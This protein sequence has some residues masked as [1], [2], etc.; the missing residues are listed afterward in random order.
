MQNLQVLTD[1]SGGH[2]YVNKYIS[3]VDKQNTVIVNAHPHKGNAVRLESQFL[4]N[5]KITTSAINEEKNHEKKRNSWHPTG[6]KVAVPEMLHLALGESEVHTNMSWVEIPTCPLELRAGVE[7][8]KGHRQNANNRRNQNNSNNNNN[9]NNN[10]NDNNRYRNNNNRTL[11]LADAASVDSEINRIRKL[12][13]LPS[14]R[15][16]RLPELYIVQ[17]TAQCSITID[18]VTKFSLRPPELRRLFDSLLNYY[19]WFDIGKEYLMS[20]EMMVK[21]QTDITKTCWIDGLHHQV[22]IRKKAFG[23]VLSYLESKNDQNDIDDFDNQLFNFIKEI[24]CLQQQDHLSEEQQIIS[25]E[26]QILRHFAREELIYED[27][28][29]VF[30]HVPVPS[31]IT[32]QNAHQF[33]LHYLLKYGRFET[34]VDLT[35][36]PS[37]RDSF[38]YAKLIGNETDENSLIRYSNI[39]LRKYIVE[40]VFEYSFSIKDL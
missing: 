36:H 6:A 14:E 31:L 3:K 37:V 21:V 7:T 40:E 13:R 8:M 12:K 19:R 10:N 30:L 28:D 32:P 1:R 33:I 35:T 29:T 9:N 39:L 22:R 15:Q 2:Q 34:E 26:Q 25:E 27:E 23:E 11:G 17:G 18:R 38:R 16:M 24:I 4:H 20:D 5:T